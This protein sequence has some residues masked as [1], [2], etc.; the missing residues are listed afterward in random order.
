M[1]TRV[2]SARTGALRCS[3][4]THGSVPEWP[5]GAD[6]KSAGIVLRRFES[7]PAHPLIARPHPG[8]GDCTFSPHYPHDP[9]RRRTL[10]ASRPSRPLFADVSLTISDGDRLGV[11]GLNGIGQGTLLRMLAGELRARGRRGAPRPGRARRRSSTRH[12]ML[13][14]GHGPRRGRRRVARR[15]DARPAGHGR[16]CSSAD[17]RAVG[18]PGQ[19]GRAGR[20][21]W[22]A[23]TTLLILD[24][25]TNHLDLDAIAWLEDWLA[26]LPRRPGAR[27]PRPPRARPGHDQGPRA[28][29]RRRVPARPTGGTPA[30]LRRVPRRPGRARGAGRGRRAGP[31]RTW[32]R[33]EL[34]WLR[35]GAPARTSQAEGPHRRRH[36]ARRGPGP[37]G[38]PRRRARPARW[39]RSGWAPRAS[40][41]TTSASRG[42][43]APTVLDRVL[44]GRST[45]ASGSASSA[46]NGAGKS[47]LLD[48]V[49]GRLPPTDGPVESRRTVQI[50]YYDQLGRDLDPTQRVRDAVA[51]DKGEPSLADVTLMRAVLVRRRRPVRADRHAVAVASAGGCSC[52]SRC[53][54]A[55]QRA[56]ARRADQRPRPRHAAGARG[57]PRRLAGH[58]RRRS[59]TTGPS[60]TGSPTSCSRSTAAAACAGCAAASPPGSPTHA[61]VRRRR[62]PRSPTRL[63]SPKPAPQRAQPL[64][65]PPP[66]RPSRTGPGGRHRRPRRLG[67]ELTSTTEH[68]QL[69]RLSAELAAAQAKLAAAEEQWLALAAEAE[70]LGLDL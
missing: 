19:A 58:R 61:C 26:A 36:G 17:R 29:P 35:R 9:H 3:W 48:L 37:G 66:A 54:R 65:R 41:C 25:P 47:T 7:F 59:A 39:A 1:A 50:G 2:A 28:R 18:R 6:C 15:G 46:P 69:V 63:E 11:V 44:A 60:S 43:T 33:R 68:E 67:D 27:H 22:S 12:P 21:C 45:R 49:A 10:A 13:P 30:R 38:R 16:R 53:V 62:P 4:S 24:E 34:A 56:A 40:S 57:L 51:G 52:C 42:R 14:A 31:A 5:K 64:D 55:A 32:P 70:A 20:D 8:P 23:S